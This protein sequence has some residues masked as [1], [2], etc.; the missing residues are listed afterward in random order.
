VSVDEALYRDS[1]KTSAAEAVKLA[2]DEARAEA[3]LLATTESTPTTGPSSRSQSLAS[4]AAAATQRIGDI[5]AELADIDQQLSHG[6]TTQPA[7]VLEARRAKLEAELN[8]TSE[9][10]DALMNLASFM[11]GSESG[12]AVLLQKIDD[13]EHT[14]PDLPIDTAESILPRPTAAGTAGALPGRAR[15]RARAARFPGWRRSVPPRQ[16]STVPT[17]ALLLPPPPPPPVWGRRRFGRRRRESSAWSPSS[18]R[19]PAE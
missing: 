11:G 15:F 3:Q 10:R 17:A 12:S 14:V 2:F 9:R 6:P 4:A 18:S 8:L 19:S 5:N 16:R 7:D 13:L 1:V